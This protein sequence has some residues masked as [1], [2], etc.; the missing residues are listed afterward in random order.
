MP[1][2][3]TIV[4]S[5]LCQRA[6]LIINQEFMYDW[7][8]YKMK[9]TLTEFLKQ[10]YSNNIINYINFSKESLGLSNKKHHVCTQRQFSFSLS[11]P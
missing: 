5:S 8:V 11:N 1:F 3:E 4:L 6:T 2:L 7:P 9:L 10:P